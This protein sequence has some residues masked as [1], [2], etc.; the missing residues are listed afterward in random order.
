M[1]EWNTEFSTFNENEIGP[2]VIVNRS[3]RFK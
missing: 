2:E 1:V 3:E